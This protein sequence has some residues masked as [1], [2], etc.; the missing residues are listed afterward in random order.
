MER[1][2]VM[3]TGAHSMLLHAVALPIFFLLFVVF[4]E[5]FAIESLLTME[6]S[7]FTFNVTMLFCILLISM[8]ITRCWLYFI[9]KV[10]SL[11]RIEYA[12]WCSAEVL[13]GSLFMAL[14]LSLMMPSPPPYYEL[15]GK[16]LK[17]TAGTCIYPYLFIWIGMEAKTIINSLS[18]RGDDTSL[19]RFYDEYKKLR[20]VIA[21]EAVLYIKSED[22]YAQIHYLDKGR[23]Q[24]FILRSSMKALEDNLKQHGL[25]RC[26]RSYFV[27]P[28]FIKIV[29]RNDAGQI[30]AELNQEGYESI[31]ISQKYQDQIANIV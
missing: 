26:H 18:Q 9:G 3:V 13:L 16:A 22:N 31:P 4:Y 14:Y 28:T 2:N 8:S 29:H 17:I 15:V 12:L 30:V 24:K 27:N 6:K 19:I 1:N 25:I 23:S 10:R 20:F 11:S 5:P 21:P 7:S